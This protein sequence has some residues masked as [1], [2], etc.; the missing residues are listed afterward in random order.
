MELTLTI[1]AIHRCQTCLWERGRGLQIS[2]TSTKPHF[3]GSD[4]HATIQD[5]FHGTCRIIWLL[6]LHDVQLLIITSSVL[7]HV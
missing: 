6:H 7:G 3:W 2:R 4:L 1:A 5:G